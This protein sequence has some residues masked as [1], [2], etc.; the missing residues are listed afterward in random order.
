M[1]AASR[2][3]ETAL[4]KLEKPLFLPLR[5]VV[6]IDVPPPS[7]LP[8]VLHPPPHRADQYSRERDGGEEEE[9]EGA[10]MFWRTEGDRWGDGGRTEGW[11][12]NMDADA[13]GTETRKDDKR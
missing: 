10:V 6:D 2:A 7:A 13:G 12:S 3:E 1:A 8:T 9:E 4:E 11:T 5:S